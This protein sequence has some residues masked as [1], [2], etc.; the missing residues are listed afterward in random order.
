MYDPNLTTHVGNI[1]LDKPF[2]NASGCMCINHEDLLILDE[3]ET[4]AV[5]T[6]T[7][8]YEPR[9]GN[10]EPRY[11]ESEHYSINSMG[12]PNKGFLYYMN[13]AENKKNLKP[14]FFSISTMNI[15][16]TYDMVNKIT[17]NDKC[18]IQ[19]I[20]F[21]IS[22][23]NIIGKGQM[24]YDIKQLD[25]FLKGLSQ[26]KLF[27]I[28]RNQMA[29]GLKMSP[30]FDKYQFESVSDI[31]KNYPRLDFITCI[32]GIGR[33][34]VIDYNN[35]KSMIKPNQGLGG[36]GGKIVKPTGLANVKQ[37]K[38]ILG[39]KLD[40]IGC[41]GIS[42]GIDSFEYILAGASCLSVGTHLIKEGPTIFNRLNNEL[43]SIMKL[44]NYKHIYDFKH[45]LNN[46]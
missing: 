2:I 22:C 16:N 15:N 34:L 13:Y 35:E 32:N 4:G 41:G 26:T 37:F 10:P 21:N 31:I 5:M 17:S 8:T 45:N 36:L 12:L 29:I 7:M 9:E 19:G 39:D 43:Y 40:I 20:E 6:K 11:Y 44:K 1:K 46:F 38:D 33:G 3:N 24:G 30:Y 25:D 42:S 23:P 28:T 14:L 27:D 18:N